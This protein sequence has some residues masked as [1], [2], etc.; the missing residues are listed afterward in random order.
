MALGRQQY[1]WEGLQAQAGAPHGLQQFQRLAL[2]LLARDPAQRC[3][4]DSALLQ[5]LEAIE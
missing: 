3:T 2:A 5:V 1:P 4:A